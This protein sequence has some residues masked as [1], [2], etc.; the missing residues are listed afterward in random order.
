V[1]VT[2]VV[3]MPVVTDVVM[4]PVVTGGDGGGDDA[5]GDRRW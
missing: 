5:C 4:M 3:M 1:V 2:E